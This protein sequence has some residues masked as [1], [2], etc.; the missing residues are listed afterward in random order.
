MY[1]YIGPNNQQQGPVPADQLLSRGVTGETMVWKAGMAQWQMAK[2]V[3]ELS[4]YFGRSPFNAE[5]TIDDQS[6][7][8]TPP[9]PNYSNYGNYGNNGSYGNYGNYG[10]QYGPQY[11][12]QFGQPTG[13]KPDSHLVWAILATLF[14]WYPLLIGFAFGIVSIVYASKVD[15]AWYMGR[16]M[17]AEDYSRKARN[18][19][20]AAALSSIVGL[21]LIF[22][23]LRISLFG[24]LYR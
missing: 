2:D 21:V 17:E 23:I 13:P 15:S 22:V 19:A 11:G 14:C 20:L 6:T 4:S 7:R 12:G 16:Q 1:Y 18:W 8:F 5:K 9:P 3:P 24:L 10:P